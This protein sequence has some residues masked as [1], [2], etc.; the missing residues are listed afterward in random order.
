MPHE[1]EPH[2]FWQEI[3]QPGT[4]AASG[5][6]S[7]FYPAELADG[8]Q[9][10]LPIRP[11]PDGQHALASLII[12]QASFAVVEVL[13]E[14]LARR[15][16]AF[17]PDVVVGL[18]TLGLTLAAAV[19]R[20]LGHSRYVPLGTSRKFWY[21]DRLSVPLSSITTPD[22]V[23]RLYVDPRMLPLL[24]NRRVALV[25]DVIS[26]GSSILAGLSLLRSID[27]EPIAIGA[28][29]LQSDRWHSTL[30]SCGVDWWN[31]VCGAVCTPRLTKI[32]DGYWSL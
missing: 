22:Q 19:A 27:V 10:R 6:F 7:G 1:I 9:I 23:K 14:D 32:K 3:H 11:L 12:N 25:D 29:M 31:Q 8:R 24:K 13:A 21:E 5:P 30:E 20:H 17:S 26:S 4:F 2:D 16:S 18:P 28:A 15:L